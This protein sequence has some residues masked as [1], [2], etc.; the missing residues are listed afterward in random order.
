MVGKPLCAYCVLAPCAG[1]AHWQRPLAFLLGG[2]HTLTV[3]ARCTAKQQQ[4]PPSAAAGLRARLAPRPVPTAAATAALLGRLCPLGWLAAAAGWWH[5]LE[6]GPNRP[7]L[8]GGSAGHCRRQL[9]FHPGAGLKIQ[10]EGHVLRL[11]HAWPW[12]LHRCAALPPAPPPLP[13]SRLGPPPAYPPPN[14]I[15]CCLQARAFSFA[16]GGM[17]AATRTHR[18]LLSAVLHLPAAFFDATPLGRILN[19]FSS[20]TCA[21]GA[22]FGLRCRDAAPVK[23]TRA[24]VG[25]IFP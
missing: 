16:K 4:L 7:L 25:H 15:S 24:A 12:L 3:T 2:T 6:P 5:G 22:A 17:L 19:R 13:A 23:C 14:V 9:P 20:D 18:R 10:R 21:L 8:P 1:H 11:H